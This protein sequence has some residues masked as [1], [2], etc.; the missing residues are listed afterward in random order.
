MLLVVV[1]TPKGMVARA[2]KLCTAV[3]VLA[4]IVVASTWIVNW[5]QNGP[6]PSGPLFNFPYRFG[7]IDY[8]VKAIIEDLTI[9]IGQT[10]AGWFS[11]DLG[12]SVTVVCACLLLLGG[13][14]Q[15]FLLG[16]LDQWAA[17][18]AGTNAGLAVLGAYAMWIARSVFLWVAP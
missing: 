3:H 11:L 6:S 15:W 14:L 5:R 16:K 13:T 12:A 18:T 1:W 8:L 17:A 7:R 9:K 10:A 2:G 4:W